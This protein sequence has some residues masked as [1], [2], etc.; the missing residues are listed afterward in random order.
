[1]RPVDVRRRRSTPR[2]GHLR[3]WNFIIKQGSEEK[4]KQLRETYIGLYASTKQLVKPHLVKKSQNAISSERGT[5][6]DV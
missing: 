6:M 2:S 1:M 3:L 5:K 4:D